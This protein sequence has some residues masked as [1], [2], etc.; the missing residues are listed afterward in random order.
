MH[1]I[2]VALRRTVLFTKNFLQKY[3]DIVTVKLTK[4]QPKDPIHYYT[5]SDNLFCENVWKHTIPI[6]IHNKRSLEMESY[7][8]KTDCMFV[9]T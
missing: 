3:R 1:N 6:S 5:E 7:H 9:K 2:Y 4:I 8:V